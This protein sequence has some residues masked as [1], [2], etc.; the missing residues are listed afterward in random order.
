M[1]I[2]NKIKSHATII[3]GDN[4]FYLQMKK[5]IF[6]SKLISLNF[7]YDEENKDEKTL[8]MDD[9]ERIKL[10]LANKSS[11]VRYVIT[12]RNMRLL[13]LQNAMLKMLEEAEESTKIVFVVNSINYFIPT[14]LSRMEILDSANFTLENDKISKQNSRHNLFSEYKKKSILAKDFIALEKII[15]IDNLNDKGL[16]SKKQLREYLALI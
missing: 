13:G 10:F 11:Q 15:Q 14:I 6:E 5:E 12:N 7:D 16:I 3:T 4:N 2:L 9:L 8:K 1:S